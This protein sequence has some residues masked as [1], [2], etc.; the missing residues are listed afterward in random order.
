[1]PE[2]QLYYIAILCPDQIDR[3]VLDHKLWL[4]EQFGC[5]HALK[6]PAHLTLV[7]PFRLEES[8]EEELIQLLRT[9]TG[10]TGG[11]TITLNGFGHFSKKVLYIHVEETPALHEIK[12]QADIHFEALAGHVIKPDIRP[13]H[14]HIT[15]ATRDLS[16]HD[17]D[18]AWAHVSDLSFD[19]TFWSGTMSLLRLSPGRWQVIAE[20]N[21][22]TG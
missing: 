15:L 11:L 18:R 13:F 6:S 19:E 14:P 21:W 8:R 3:M 12:K 1:M 20:K 16:P 22:Q 5:A 7:P 4:K 10:P 17:F 9:F 2:H